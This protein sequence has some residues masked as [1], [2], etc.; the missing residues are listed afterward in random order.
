MH[1]AAS[2]PT[3]TY[4]GFAQ[5]GELDVMRRWAVLALS[6][7]LVVLAANRSQLV[8]Q[9]PSMEP[10]LWPGDR[11]LTLPAITRALRAGTVVVVT[12]PADPRHRL[13]KR[14]RDVG[15]GTVDLR[16][17]APDRSTDSRVW[18]RRPIRSVRRVALARWPDLRTPLRR[19][20]ALHRVPPT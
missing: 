3:E 8:V 5:D 11:L 6:V 16:G 18:G 17:D 19:V 15:N 12:D 2:G 13:V 20:P 14:I 10:A 7:Y 1:P 4:E 9:G